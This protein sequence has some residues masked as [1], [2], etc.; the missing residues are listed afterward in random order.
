MASAASEWVMAAAFD[1]CIMS[2][3]KEFKDKV[4]LTM[5]PVINN[6]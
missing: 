2:L 5:A 6:S 1:L 3:A 4:R